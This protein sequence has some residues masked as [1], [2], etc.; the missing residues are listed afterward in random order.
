MRMEKIV[1][2]SEELSWSKEYIAHLKAGLLVEYFPENDGSPCKTV[3]DKALALEEELGAQKERLAAPHGD[4][5][6]WFIN[7]YNKQEGLPQVG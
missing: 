2:S 4:V 6:V 1:L 3:L 7:K 5:I